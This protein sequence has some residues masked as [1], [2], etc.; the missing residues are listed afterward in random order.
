MVNT[1]ALDYS[2]LIRLFGGYMIFKMAAVSHLA[3]LKVKFLLARVV[4]RLVSV[5]ILSKSG[6]A[7]CSMPT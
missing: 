5:Y 1:E 7:G 6:L 3:L 2:C 4:K